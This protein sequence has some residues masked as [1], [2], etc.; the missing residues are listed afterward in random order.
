MAIP[1]TGIVGYRAARGD[2]YGRGVLPNA[3]PFST[4]YVTTPDGSRILNLGNNQAG[5]PRAS[6]AY[7]A[8]SWVSDSGR[9]D[10]F[11]P[12]PSAAVTIG[13]LRRPGDNTT[14]LSVSNIVVL[15]F[16]VAALFV[17]FRRG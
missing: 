16:I 17:F 7:G 2:K 13:N 8:A 3:Y 12:D 9:S 1:V 10:A 4:S 14:G 11:G 15:G 5:D 6:P